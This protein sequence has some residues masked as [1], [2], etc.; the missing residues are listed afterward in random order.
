MVPTLATMALKRYSLGRYAVAN[1]RVQASRFH[2]I[3]VGR[4][5]VLQVRQQAAEVKQV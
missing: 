4:Q 3:H 5:C 2:Q 1:E